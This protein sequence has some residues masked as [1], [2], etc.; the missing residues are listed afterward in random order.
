MLLTSRPEFKA[1]LGIDYTIGKFIFSL[2]N[3]LFG[4]TRFRNSG[5]EPSLGI[6]FETKVVTDLGITYQIGKNTTLALNANNLFNVLPKWKFVAIKDPVTGSTTDGENIMADPDA[7]RSQYNLITF[8]G[9]YSNVTYDGSHFSQ[10]G[11]TFMLAL[12][13]RF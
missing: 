4:P 3:T 13:V 12:N 11:T 7:I 8:N 5:L 10:L 1:I 9:R 2:N 6:E